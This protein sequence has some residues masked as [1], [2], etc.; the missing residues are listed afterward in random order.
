MSNDPQK[1]SHKKSTPISL[2]QSKSKISVGRQDKKSSKLEPETIAKV[3]ESNLLAK[4]YVNTHTPTLSSGRGRE[5]RTCHQN[6]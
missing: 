1:I 5:S 3:Y 4:M 6:G 2:D